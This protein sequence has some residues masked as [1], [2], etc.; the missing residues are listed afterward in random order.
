MALGIGKAGTPMSDHICYEK[1]R[2]L[3][4]KGCVEIVGS[5]RSGTRIRLK[6]PTEINGTVPAPSDRVP[7]NIEELDFFDV[8]ELRQLILEREAN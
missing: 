7:V 8:P 2:S 1:L 3:Q 6:L 4:A 5:E